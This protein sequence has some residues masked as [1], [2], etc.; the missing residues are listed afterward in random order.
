MKVMNPATRN[1][2]SLLAPRLRLMIYIKE[3]DKEKPYRRGGQVRGPARAKITRSSGPHFLYYP[4]QTRFHE[5]LSDFGF[6]LDCHFPHHR[7]H[8]VARRLP[9]HAEICN[10]CLMPSCFCHRHAMS[11][12]KQHGVTVAKTRWGGV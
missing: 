6:L 5:K 7:T 4:S 1:R 3:E 10:L 11:G 12:V 8:I 2:T 9:S